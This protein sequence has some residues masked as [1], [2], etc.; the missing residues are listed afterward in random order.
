MTFIVTIHSTYYTHS[1]LHYNDIDKK[2]CTG[3]MIDKLTINDI[4]KTCHM[5][6]N[7]PFFCFLASIE[8]SEISFLDYQIIKAEKD[9]FFKLFFFLSFSFI[10]TTICDVYCFGWNYCYLVEDNL[11]YQH[12]PH[13]CLYLH[14]LSA[15]S[16]L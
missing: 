15:F 11:V 13:S 16:D 9:K 2:M 7:W 8:S 4:W 10:L 14:R 3:N 5:V 6:K 12:H 1:S